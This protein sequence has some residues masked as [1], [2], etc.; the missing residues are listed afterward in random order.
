MRAA[1][2]GLL[3]CLLLVASVAA[4]RAAPAPPFPELFPDATRFAEEAGPPAATAAYRSDE[5]LGWA[6]SSGETVGSVG[7]S[8]RALDIL[9]GLDAQGR[10]A[11]ARLLSEEEPIFAAARTRKELESF[12]EGYKGRPVGAHLEVRRGGGEGAVAAVSGATISSLVI[13]DAIWRAARAVARA[14]GLFGQPGGIDRESFEPLDWAALVAEGSIAARRVSLGDAA[15]LLTQQGLRPDAAGD[16]SS[17]FIELFLG[18]AS[19][20]RVG[21][22][23]IGAEPFARLTAGL[24]P[25]DHLLFL[26]SRGRYSFKGTA[27]VRTGSFDRLAL[28]Q[29]DRTIRFS[30]EDHIRIDELEVGGAP[31]LREAALFVVRAGQGFQPAEPFRLQLLIPGRD[32]QGERGHAV[33]E[34]GYRLPARYVTPAPPEAP[35]APAWR[36]VWLG[37]I[38]D[39]LVLGAALGTLTGVLFFQDGLARRRWL[40]ARLRIAFLLFTLLWIGWYATAQ[41]SVVNVL[42]FGDALRTGFRWDFFLLEPLIFVLWCYVAVGLIFWG[43]GVFCGWLCPFGALQELTNGAA[44]RFKVPQVQ[45]PFWLHERLRALKFVIFLALFAVA[46]GAM[47][48]AQ[49]LAE[50][51]PFKTAIVLRFLR[52]W[53]YVVWALLLLLAGLFVER[54]FCRYL[55]PLGAVL[56]LPARLRQFE[57]LKR[58][59]QCGRECRICQVQCPV[60]A[61]QPEGTI[62]PGECV[63]CLKCQ[64][65]YHDDR[66]CPPMIER[67]RRAERRVA[68]AG[69]AASGK[70]G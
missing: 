25:D 64:C 7:Y 67:R 56:A 29:G 45:V 60:G 61:I 35:P 40:W 19:P 21:R 2:T 23:L 38:P 6:F 36:E 62:H 52:E 3:A 14:K 15:A 24:G 10:I 12:L 42:T 13:H 9:V 70:A 11:G 51:E 58:H 22:N 17:L 20:A 16:P 54:F 39:L 4:G 69:K 34:T 26:A 53:P 28:A 32:A 49:R 47:A 27:W 46:L 57:W 68:L 18:L 30:S 33:L 31:E 37:R 59:W 43:R 1:L 65:N 44:R 66:L 48:E 50:I 55:C 5:L 41:L 8:G 63:Y